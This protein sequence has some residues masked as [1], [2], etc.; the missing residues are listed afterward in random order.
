M[1]IRDST[2]GDCETQIKKKSDALMEA[3]SEI[4]KRACKETVGNLYYSIRLFLYEACIVPSMLYEVKA[5]GA[6]G[7]EIGSLE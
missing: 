7:T 1:C 2:E 5:W 3:V 4:K 6:S